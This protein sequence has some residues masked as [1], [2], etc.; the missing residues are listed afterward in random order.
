MRKI[1]KLFTIGLSLV[2]LFTTGNM[3]S[4]GKEVNIRSNPQ[5]VIACREDSILEKAEKIPEATIPLQ[6]EQEIAIEEGDTLWDI[7]R[8]YGVSIRAI[9][10]ANGITGDNILIG[11]KLIIPSQEETSIVEAKATSKLEKTE[12]IAVATAYCPCFSCCGKHE[13]DESYGITASG[14][15]VFSN[16]K[17]IIAADTSVLPFGTEVELYRVLKSGTEEYIGKYTVEDRGGAVKGERID[18]FYLNHE[19]A[20]N[21][22]RN[23]VRVKVVSTPNM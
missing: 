8:A 10:E 18:I 13:D 11:Q 14:Y 6:K 9:K 1:T 7:A 17:Q 16:E 5:P 15:N 22:G 12:F 2:S 21:F 19:D 4:L 3:L 23:E 20:L